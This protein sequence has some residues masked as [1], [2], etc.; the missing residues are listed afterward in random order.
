MRSRI[1]DAPCALAVTTFGVFMIM[2]PVTLVIGAVDRRP[3]LTASFGW[4]ADTAPLACMVASTASLWRAV[5]LPS[6]LPGPELCDQARLWLGRVADAPE[7][8][9][10]LKAPGGPGL[11]AVL[12]AYAF[13]NLR[14]RSVIDVPLPEVAKAEKPARGRI[15]RLSA[16]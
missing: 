3:A 4:S 11:A 7:K 12:M 15:V 10:P 8:T 6:P 16:A 2:P 13:R 1:D 5:Q 9:L 14:V